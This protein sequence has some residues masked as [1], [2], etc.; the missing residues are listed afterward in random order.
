MSAHTH[1]HTHAHDT[2]TKP[3]CCMRLSQSDANM[4]ARLVGVRI[5]LTSMLCR[6]AFNFMW[7]QGRHL[8][9][10]H[11]CSRSDLTVQSASGCTER[12]GTTDGTHTRYILNRK[13]GSLKQNVAIAAFYCPDTNKHAKRHQNNG[14]S[15]DG[16]SVR[17]RCRINIGFASRNCQPSASAPWDPLGPFPLGTPW[18]R[19]P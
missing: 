5:P 14:L 15:L 11:D 16:Q 19:R 10:G 6:D 9:S 17:C 3:P 12:L 7:I 4:T 18:D 13:S 8:R 2:H 1:K